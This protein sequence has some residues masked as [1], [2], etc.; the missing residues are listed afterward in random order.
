[1][2]RSQAAKERLQGLIAELRSSGR[3]KL[4]PERLLAQE[5]GYSRSTIVKVLNELESEGTVLRKIGSGTFI[6]SASDRRDIHIAVAMRHTYYRSDSHFRKIVDSLS[7]HAKDLR[8]HIR[9]F[10]NLRRMFA[11]DPVDN[12]LLKALREKRLNGVLI[13]SRLPLS[14][15]SALSSAAPA[16][17]INNI[18]GDGSEIPC[19]SCDCFRAGFL[20][21]RHLFEKGHKKAVFV[22]NDI[23]HP[24]SGVMFSG[25]QAFW[26]NAGIALDREHILETR[27]NQEIMLERIGIF[28]RDPSFSG[29]FVRT[30]SLLPTLRLA[31]NAHGISRPL[32]IVASGAASG[33]IGPNVT[34]IDNKLD[35]MCRMGLEQLIARIN[36]PNTPLPPLTLLK[37]EISHTNH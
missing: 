33:Q 26:E 22:T 23:S 7:E 29:C 25:F 10:D 34:L 27:N 1:M 11:A 20:A 8:V 18:F 28:F 21:G 3:E 12:D 17:A 32:D 16:A 30:A 5:L 31:L 15:T 24:E 2:L 19:I 35:Q 14:I 37:P 36:D 13:V 6:A 9:I 4:P